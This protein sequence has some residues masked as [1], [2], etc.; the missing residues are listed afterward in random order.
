MLNKILS[1]FGVT[2]LMDTA[3][4]KEDLETLLSGY[5]IDFISEKAYLNG[6]RYLMAHSKNSQTGIEGFIKISNNKI[7][8]E[9]LKKEKEF[10]HF[11]S[12]ITRRHGFLDN[13]HVY[14]PIRKIV[15]KLLIVF[16]TEFHAVGINHTSPR[17]CR[18]RKKSGE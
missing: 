5:A 16:L 6:S 14:L 11:Q 9:N 3:K 18:K 10:K 1:F 15:K 12:K 7:L 8:V 2:R 13:D 4:V 17:Q